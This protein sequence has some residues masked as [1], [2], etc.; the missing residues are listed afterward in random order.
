[1]KDSSTP[2]TKLDIQLLMEQMAKLFGRFHTMDEKIN[3]LV[4]EKTLDKKLKALE[5][6]INTETKDYFNIRI[7]QIEHVLAT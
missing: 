1:M 5:K 4:D 2:A 6:H 3:S 7:T